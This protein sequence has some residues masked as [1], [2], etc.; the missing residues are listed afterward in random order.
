M[1]VSNAKTGAIED[2]KRSRKSFIDVPFN[3][4]SESGADPYK[5]TEDSAA[6]ARR[7]VYA[8]RST[9]VMSSLCH[10]TRAAVAAKPAGSSG[11]RRNHL[12]RLPEG[13][14]HDGGIQ[15]IWSGAAMSIMR[16]PRPRVEIAQNSPCL[17]Y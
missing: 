11:C 4:C 10:R 16:A 13:L 6:L 15:A 9:T 2:A 5:R 14:P 17:L 7:G 1:L 3:C 8:S 12:C